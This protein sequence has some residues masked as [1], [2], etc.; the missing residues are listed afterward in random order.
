MSAATTMLRGSVWSFRNLD[1]DEPEPVI[2]VSSDG[3][4]TSRP[5]TLSPR[6]RSLSSATQMIRGVTER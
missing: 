3:R 2:I 5:K 6:P 1:T 4:I